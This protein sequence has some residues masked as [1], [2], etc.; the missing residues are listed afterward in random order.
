[1]ST[2]ALPAAHLEVTPPDT[3]DIHSEDGLGFDDGDVDI[4]LDFGSP[5]GVD[6]DE[7]LRDAGTDAGQD[8]QA[9]L[10]D[11]DDFMADN[12]DIIDEDVV[13]EDVEVDLHPHSAEHTNALE[14]SLPAGLEDDLID[15]SDDED[16]IV[17]E[18]IVATIARQTDSL[19]DPVIP[20]ESGDKSEGNPSHPGS[21]AGEDEA[22]LQDATDTR[23]E[24]SDLAPVQSPILYTTQQPHDA[25]AQPDEQSQHDLHDE[26]ETSTREVPKQERRASDPTVFSTTTG[27]DDSSIEHAAQDAQDA[28]FHPVNVNFN[29]KDYW[30]FQH[31][32]YEG[33]GDYLLEDDSLFKQP[34]NAV[35]NACREALGALDVD[36]PGDLELGFRLDSLHHVELYEEHST[37][38][39]FSLDD[40]L[41]VYMQLYAQ[42]GITDPD[43]FCVTLLSRPRISSLLA[44]LS[45]AAAEGIGYSG[46]DNVIASGLTLFPVH[47]FHSPTEHSFGE[48]EGGDRQETSQAEDHPEVCEQDYH[49]REQ[50]EN[51]DREGILGSHEKGHG[52]DDWHQENNEQ[53][54]EPELEPKPETTADVS[55]E[56]VNAAVSK[57]DNATAGTATA[58]A[59][60]TAEQSIIH[61]AVLEQHIQDPQENF[62]DYSDDESDENA[63][64]DQAQASRISSTS[65]TVQGDDPSQT[66][67]YAKDV[68]QD[69]QQGHHHDEAP[70]DDLANLSAGALAEYEGNDYSYGE[71]DGQAYGETYEEEYEQENIEGQESEGYAAYDAAQANVEN[72]NHLGD[73]KQQSADHAEDLSVTAELDVSEPDIVDDT[74]EV[75]EGANDFL[76]FEDTI[77]A[78][79]QSVNNDAAEDE[80]DYSDEEDGAVGQALVAPS[81]AADTVVASSTEPQNLSPQGQKRSIDEVGNDVVDATISTGMLSRNRPRVQHHADMS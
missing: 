77:A 35:I 61:T 28:N 7:S 81:A 74:F 71:F 30:L 37:C 11:Q 58:N 59:S 65:A 33:S 73:L 17:G 13:D 25:S 34:L 50:Q 51:H 62:L 69:E 1:M 68:T 38:V 12:E 79:Q 40:I 3:M 63:P 31:H 60:K 41:R 10:G 39:F 24:Q 56:E 67:E 8:M 23:Q 20:A 66:Q 21:H 5:G 72:T 57:S 22:R 19:D 76:D 48:W 70:H 78:P 14:T 43:Y 64:G 54:H 49:K 46:L 26:L 16:A 47:D 15:Y 55:E 4:D 44:E 29:G 53:E 52:D 2:A 80:L 6:D 42:D 45:R 75:F 32:D 27:V 9:V 36:V 18:S